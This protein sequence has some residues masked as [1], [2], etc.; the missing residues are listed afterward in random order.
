MWITLIVLFVLAA[1][2]LIIYLV[3]SG[4]KEFKPKL[5]LKERM[6]LEHKIDEEDKHKAKRV[7]DSEID[8]ENDSEPEEVTE[9]EI[10][11][12]TKPLDTFPPKDYLE[13]LQKFETIANSEN[14]EFN[15]AFRSAITKAKKNDFRNSLTEF[16]KALDIKNDDAATLYCRALVKC[17]LNNYESAAGDLTGAISA[18]LENVNALFYRGVA[19]YNIKEYS[20]ALQ[21]FS[22]F[23]NVVEDYPLVFHYLG[24]VKSKTMDYDGAI[25]NF[26]RA[27]EL[28]PLFAES[29]FERAMAKEFL[30]DRQGCC[31]DLK[32]AMNKGHLDSYHYIKKYCSE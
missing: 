13:E 2:G 19:R 14:D 17:K 20:S 8:L 25:E 6:E 26:S 31:S 7:T 30:G 5:T 18:D 22:S 9:K 27:V 21:D 4:S 10:E 15:L 3:K 28:N 23:V 11:S 16:S 29:Y 32:I 1:V 24:L 12:N